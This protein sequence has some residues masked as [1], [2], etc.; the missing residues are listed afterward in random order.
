MRLKAYQTPAHCTTVCNANGQDFTESYHCSN[1]FSCRAIVRK[2]RVIDP[3]QDH[4]SRYCSMAESTAF[5]KSDDKRPNLHRHGHCLWISWRKAT[6]RRKTFVLINSHMRVDRA[7]EGLCFDAE[8]QPVL[9]QPW[10]CKLD[11]LMDVKLSDP[12]HLLWREGD[13]A[14][15]CMIDTTGWQTNCCNWICITETQLHA[16]RTV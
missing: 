2:H 14:V 10:R 12:F 11:P 1:Y 9:T 5:L 16:N 8:L 7:W 15:C 6:R 3:V 4:V 13:L